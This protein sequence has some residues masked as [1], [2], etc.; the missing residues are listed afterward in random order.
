MDILLLLMLSKDFFNHFYY[1]QLI[2]SSLE[3]GKRSIAYLKILL[4]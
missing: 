4:S 2:F 1:D 3:K